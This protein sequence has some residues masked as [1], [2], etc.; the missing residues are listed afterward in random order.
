MCKFSFPLLP[1]L[2]LS[3][4]FCLAVG[5]TFCQC[6]NICSQSE[7][8]GNGSVLGILRDDWDVRVEAHHQNGSCG[9][10][11]TCHTLPETPPS[12]SLSE[13]RYC[14]DVLM[15]E[16]NRQGSSCPF[17]ISCQKELSN[18]IISTLTPNTL[19]HTKKSTVQQHSHAVPQA[20]FQAVSVRKRF[21]SPDAPGEVCNLDTARVLRFIQYLCSHAW[22]MRST[23]LT[24]WEVA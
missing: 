3:V 7:N 24:Q 1:S 22:K 2:P 8:S 19:K 20:R 17:S 4:W 11:I 5:E 14:R 12:S 9:H 15:I 10:L 6:K 23:G 21:H 16:Q 18:D 13:C